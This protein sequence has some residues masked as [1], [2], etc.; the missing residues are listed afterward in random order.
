MTAS[1]VMDLINDGET[2]IVYRRISDPSEYVKL[3]ASELILGSFK[4]GTNSKTHGLMLWASMGEALAL[5]YLEAYPNSVTHEGFKALNSFMRQWSQVADGRKWNSKNFP[6]LREVVSVTHAIL[7]PE[8]WR[9]F[10][11]PPEGRVEDATQLLRR[12]ELHDMVGYDS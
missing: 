5:N 1:E 7:Y 9:I 10:I 3:N 11:V 8:A 12:E 2:T 4:R 6:S